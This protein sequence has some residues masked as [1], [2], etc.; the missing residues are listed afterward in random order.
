[1]EALQNLKRGKRTRIQSGYV[2]SL[3]AVSDV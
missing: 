1:M 3:A 2:G